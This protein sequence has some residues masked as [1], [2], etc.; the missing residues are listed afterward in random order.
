MKSSKKT[1][2]RGKPKTVYSSSSIESTE[3]KEFSLLRINEKEEIYF[4]E[5]S[6]KSVEIER[7]IKLLE[8][9]PR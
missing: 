6:I 9:K 4:I 2:K 3:Q 7:Q 1:Y 5:E 8:F